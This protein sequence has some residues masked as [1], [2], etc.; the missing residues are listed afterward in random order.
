[1]DWTLEA[2]ILPV[3]DLARSV[4]FYRELPGRGVGFR[5]D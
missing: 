5:A 3:S 1:M 4:E 2:V